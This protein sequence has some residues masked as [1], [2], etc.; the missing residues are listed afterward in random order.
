MHKNVHIA[1]IGG[2]YAGCAAA[3]RLIEFGYTPILFEASTM[4][5]G[6]ARAVSTHTLTNI[7]NG[8]HLLLGAYH[9]TLELIQK[10]HLPSARL[11][12]L[13]EIIPLTWEIPTQLH[14]EAHPTYCAPFHLL[15][16]LLQSQTLSTK[17]KLR[18]LQFFLKIKLGAPP[19]PTLSVTE[20]FD[21]AQLPTRLQALL[22][23]PLCL[24]ALNTPAELASA[25]RLYYVIKDS[26]LSFNANDSRYYIPRCDLSTLFPKQA[27]LWIEERGGHV[28]T[29]S[30]VQAVT[31][32][33]NGMFC[34]TIQNEKTQKQEKFTHVIYATAP[35][36]LSSLLPQ[37]AALG[38]LQQQLAQIK[39][40]PI[41][42]VYLQYDTTIWT[43]NQPRILMLPPDCTGQWLFFL[44]RQIRCVMS[45]F[46]AQKYST[47]TELIE[48]IEKEIQVYFQLKSKHIAVQ[49]ITEKRA[50]YLATPTHPE[51]LSETLLPNLYLAGDYLHPY[52][53]ATLESATQSGLEAAMCLHASIDK[54]H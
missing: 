29:K 53:P 23:T 3:V 35:Y 22:L 20:W 17:E 13:F 34:L 2:G 37:C 8:Q 30:R 45:A 1:I 51:I 25:Y 43:K 15:V 31:W 11:E 33:K 40:A 41:C 42:T 48:K 12:D 16:G 32:E 9:T 14:F 54:I 38:P 27:A 4:L 18:L 19:S 10:V 28:E 44:P 21:Q 7:D 52:Y 50:T 47:T 39:Y 26:L 36:H 6:R 24:A 46:F 5:G 49:V